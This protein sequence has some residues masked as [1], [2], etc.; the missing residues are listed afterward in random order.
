MRE[1]SQDPKSSDDSH[2]ENYLDS[3]PCKVLDQADKLFFSWE[4]SRTGK[5]KHAEPDYNPTSFLGN[6]PINEILHWHNAIKKELSDIAEE[7]RKIQHS[8]GF[9]DLSK[10]G[11]RLQFIA[12]VCI[13]HRFEAFDFFNAESPFLMTCDIFLCYLVAVGLDFFHVI[14]LFINPC[15]CL[16]SHFFK[17]CSL[18]ECHF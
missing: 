4:H 12:D 9:H 11:E 3:E 6:H 2:V 14:F 15:I 1:M 10:F 17:G 16:V 13:F 7:A 8:S 5:R 18:F